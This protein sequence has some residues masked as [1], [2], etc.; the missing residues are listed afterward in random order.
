[1]LRKAGLLSFILQLDAAIEKIRY[2]L[3]HPRGIAKIRVDFHIGVSCVIRFAQQAKLL[4]LFEA[5]RFK[6]RSG[7]LC[8]FESVKNCAW[9]RV[10]PDYRTVLRLS[11]IHI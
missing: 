7:S 3:R 1:M 10:K 11:L 2:F 8:V 5:E 4:H 9:R 6:L